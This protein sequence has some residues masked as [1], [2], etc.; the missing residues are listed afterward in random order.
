M[1]LPKSTRF[2]RISP[3]LLYGSC[4]IRNRKFSLIHP[5]R[6]TGDFLSRIWAHYGPPDSVQFRGFEYAFQDTETGL[7]FSAYSAGSGPAFGGFPLDRERLSPILDQFETIVDETSPVDCGIVY[8]TDSGLCRSGA[9]D[10]KPF[11]EDVET[12]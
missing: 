8:E 6:S 5:L 9:K 4:K 11:D 7:R 2:V 10:G 12:E 3:E 1:P